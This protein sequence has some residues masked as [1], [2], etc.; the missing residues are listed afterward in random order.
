M[1]KRITLRI[2]GG[3]QVVPLNSLVI[4]LMKII[5]VNICTYYDANKQ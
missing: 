4:I 5:P 2:R 3:L 1:E